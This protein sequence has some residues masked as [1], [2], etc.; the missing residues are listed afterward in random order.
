M[1]SHLNRLGWESRS[2]NVQ[3]EMTRWLS[4]PEPSWVEVSV[5]I[6]VMCT[7]IFGSSFMGSHLDRFSFSGS[8]HKC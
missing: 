1:S 4:G 5:S 3:E 8:C 7:N 2:Y 6:S